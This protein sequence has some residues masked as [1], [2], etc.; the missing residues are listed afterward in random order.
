MADTLSTEAY[1]GARISRD[2]VIERKLAYS[3]A[4][5]ERY[6]ASTDRRCSGM[7]VK[8]PRNIEFDEVNYDA[9]VAV[10]VI[11][12]RGNAAAMRQFASV[13]EKLHWGESRL[14]F[15]A[16][17]L[18]AEERALAGVDPLDVCAVLGDWARSGYRTIPA[19]ATRFQQEVSKFSRRT[20]THCRRVP[21]NG[22]SICSLRRPEKPIAKEIGRLL[23]RYEYGRQREIA[24]ET[25]RIENVLATRTRA[26][27]ILA[28]SLLTRHLGLDPFSLRIFVASLSEL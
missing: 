28:T 5:V 24:H 13:T 26:A 9:L 12:E 14:T 19:A 27:V 6:V 1:L 2:E 21:P 25:E 23:K 11:M 7:A 17:R 15:L 8:A 3:Q 10:E 4:V 18:A 22:R 16:R 20:V